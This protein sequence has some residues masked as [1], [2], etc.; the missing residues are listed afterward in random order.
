[1]RRSKQPDAYSVAVLAGALTNLLRD[2]E[3]L[4]DQ[5]MD[6]LA[7]SRRARG[8]GYVPEECRDIRDAVRESYVRALTER[9]ISGMSD[10]IDASGFSE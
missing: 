9:L 1:M 3:I 7:A 4:T 5:T 8:I 6:D 10:S 2:A